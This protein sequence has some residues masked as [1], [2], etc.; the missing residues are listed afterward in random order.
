MSTERPNT[1]EFLSFL[2]TCM[3]FYNM[4]LTPW[5]QSHIIPEIGK[6][7][8]DHLAPKNYALLVKFIYGESAPIYADTDMVRLKDAFT[9]GA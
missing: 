3:T 1:D 8:H 6:L 2:G 7:L 4:H 5:E 9:S